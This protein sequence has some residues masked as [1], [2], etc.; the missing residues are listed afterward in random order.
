VLSKCV[1]QLGGPLIRVYGDRH[2]WNVRLATLEALN[3][4]IK[5]VQ[6]TAM[7]VELL[8][9]PF[10]TVQVGRAAR[11][12]MPQLQTSYVKTLN[13]K[14]SLRNVRLLAVDGLKEIAPY[15]SRLDSLVTE[16]HNGIKKNDDAS[17]R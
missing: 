1:L 14:Q 12:F 16:L 9:R 6:Q 2:G 15:V 3:E 4:L 8:G 13:D 7:V 5:K 10:F 11:S 17:V